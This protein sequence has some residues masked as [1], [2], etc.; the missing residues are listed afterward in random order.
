MSL[1]QGFLNRIQK[2]LDRGIISSP[3]ACKDLDKFSG[4]VNGLFEMM[5]FSE[6]C[7][8]S[9]AVYFDRLLSRHNTIISQQNM[10]RLIF[11]SGVIAIKMNDDFSYKN[12]YYAQISGIT[13]HEINYLEIHFLQWIE[14][15]LIIKKE[16]Y[17]KYYHGLSNFNL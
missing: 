15:A 5:G 10:T 11:I 12:S 7:F 8:V 17:E 4:F 2:Y 6:G 9:M 13:N 16:E 14:Y 3:S 1:V